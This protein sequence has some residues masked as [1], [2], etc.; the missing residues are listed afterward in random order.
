VSRNFE[1]LQR[2]QVEAGQL[3]SAETATP[4][5]GTAPAAAVSDRTANDRV[6][7]AAEPGM[8]GESMKLV[9]RLFLTP[10]KEVP[11]AVTFAAI[12]SHNGCT[13]ICANTARILADSVPGTVCLVEAN[14]RTPSLARMFGMESGSGLGDALRQEGPIK[15]WAKQVGPA[16]LWLIFGGKVSDDPS[17][18]L[19]CDRLGQRIAE[20]RREFDYLVIDAPPLNAYADGMVWGRLSDGVVLILEANNTRR[21][22][23]LRVTESLRST[24]ITLLGAVLNKRTF[25]IPGVFYKRI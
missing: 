6:L 20:L 23:A 16:N 7:D 17:N 24:G 1:L 4:P 15:S 9:Q 8:R 18:P 22:A 13:R 12:D 10:G 3:P 14:F 25:P 11:K 19:D 21:E 5:V 2:L